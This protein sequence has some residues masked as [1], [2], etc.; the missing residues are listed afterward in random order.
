[1]QKG[2]GTSDFSA[3]EGSDAWMFG[4]LVLGFWYFGRP[5]VFEVLYLL[6]LFLQCG[7]C[8][9]WRRVSVVTLEFWARVIQFGLIGSLSLRGASIWSP[10]TIS[11]VVSQLCFTSIQARQQSRSPR[12]FDMVFGGNLYCL[13]SVVFYFNPGFVAIL[14]SE[15]LGHGLGGSLCSIVSVL[16]YFDISSATISV[17]ELLRPS[18]GRSLCCI[19]LTMFYLFVCTWI[20][21]ATM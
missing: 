4:A 7:V 19:V 6:C 18:L 5:L 17:S 11:V 21:T 12:C 9:I 2:S 16:L 1:M 14:V 13:V 15:V 3:S 10:A 20:C 8:C